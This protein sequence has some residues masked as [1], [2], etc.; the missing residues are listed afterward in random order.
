MQ[1]LR[2]QP[3]KRFLCHADGSPFFWLG[4]TAW[5]LFHR[6]TLEEIARYLDNR[7]AKGF[8]LVQACI[9][10]EIHGL[11]QPNAYGDLPFLGNDPADPNPSYF[12]FVGEVLRMA[13]ARGLYVGLLPT[14]GAYATPAEKPFFPNQVLFTP[15]NAGGYG[16]FVG[17]EFADRDNLVWI[18]GGDRSPE[19]TI[20]TWRAMAR[21]IRDGG[22]TQLRSYH[23]YGGT[24][25][26]DFLHNEPWLDFN[27][28]QSGHSDASRPDQQ[29]YSDYM[30]TPVKPVINGEPSYE[31][32]PNDFGKRPGK[33]DAREVRRSVYASLFSGACGVTYGCN[34]IWMMW[35][36]DLEPIHENAPAPFLQAEMP[37][38]EAM[39]RP[40]AFQVRHAKDLL[41][42]LPGF[43]ERVPMWDR[44]LDNEDD[45]QRAC[46]ATGTKDWV[47]IYS[48]G[49]PFTVNDD[50]L[51][52]DC[53]ASWFDPRTGETFPIG[54]TSGEARFEPP[55]NE[56]HVLLIERG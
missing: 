17:S 41:L 4:D 53:H 11:T 38:D 2:I 15:E 30:R 32:I 48:T 8:T 37:W 5:E 27:M 49:R 31:G 21:G 23:P 16:A 29:A 33:L 7:A 35:R 1:R 36:P 6:L 25:S 10:P 52:C 45:P 24:S 28:F 12:A 56:D 51:G 42:R 50:F 26:A 22:A 54:K 55:R 18:L 14:W 44:V 46:Y 13:E 9:V 43:F 3:S 20:A 39:D 34:E 40:G 47:A 19:H